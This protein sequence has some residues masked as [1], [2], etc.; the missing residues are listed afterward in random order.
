[1]VIALSLVY[2]GAQG[3]RG[4][5]ESFRAFGEVVFAF[6][7]V[8]GSRSVSWPLSSS[9]GS[10]RLRDRAGAARGRRHQDACRQE[11]STPPR[12]IGGDH[13]AKM[14]F[15][16]GETAA[17][18]DL[19]HVIGDGL[20][21]VRYRPDISPAE[22]EQLEAFVEDPASREYVIAAPDPEQAEPLR[23]VAAVRTLSCSQVD[24]AGLAR[25]RDDWFA[26]VQA[27]QGG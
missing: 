18:E 8:H 14:F 5:P 22:V 1:M 16:P 11:D 20:V 3:I 13:P 26:Y 4:R 21:I 25:F 12:F 6:G 17:N 7:L 15:E 23:A 27:Q 24:L 2:V 10:A 9:W 19:V